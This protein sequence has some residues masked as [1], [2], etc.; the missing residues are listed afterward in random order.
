MIEQGILLNLLEKTS[1]L[2]VVLLL[3]SKTKIFKKIVQEEDKSKSAIFLLCLTFSLL[4]IMGTYS[5]INVLG[6]LANVRNIAII[7]GGILFGPIVG[8]TSG[9]VAGLHRFLIDINGITSLP[10]LIASIFAGVISGS[11]YKRVSTNH[12]VIVG[13]ICG[14]IVES[15]SMILIIV[16]SKPYDLAVTIVN[17]I[18]LPMLSGQIGIG[19]FISILQSTQKEKDEIEARQSKIALDIAI[20]TLPFFRS[21]NDKD[22]LNKVCEIIREDIKSDAV[23]IT[24]TSKVLAYSGILESYYNKSNKSLSEKT[25]EAVE[26][27]EIIYIESHDDQYLADNK[28]KLSTAMIIPLKE[29]NKTIGT[30]KLYYCKKNNIS[31]AKRAL[32]IGLSQLLSTS[33]EISKV[34]EMRKAYNKAEIKALQT[35]INPHFLFNALNTIISFIRINPDEARNIIINLSTYLRYNLEVNDNLIDIKKEIEQVKAYVTIEKARFKDKLNVIYDIDESVDVK[36]PSLIIQPLVENAIIH[37]IRNKVGMG[38]VIISIKKCNEKV[39]IT[40]ENDGESISEEVIYNVYNKLMPENKIGLYNVY[41]RL[42]LIYGES[43][44]ITRLD[45]GTRIEFYV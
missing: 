34:E 14:V 25:K 12:K 1:F 37:G 6:S 17:T 22:A 13:I 38:S 40:I 11:I 36:I 43:L 33:L 10:C 2:I 16:L 29:N 28:T 21:I 44:N 7:S 30:L 24:D 32:A 39:K 4:A 5:G 18:Y 23:A 8:I 31:D 19:F 3:L 9:I 27:G 20:K 41:H 45:Q 35:Q 26:K 42:M 15:L